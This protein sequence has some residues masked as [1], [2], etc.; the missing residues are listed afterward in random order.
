MLDT[1]TLSLLPQDEL[2]IRNAGSE[3]HAWTEGRRILDRCKE[4]LS[5]DDLVEHMMGLHDTVRFV[6]NEQFAS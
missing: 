2:A 5:H 3:A 6:I 1:P 4:S